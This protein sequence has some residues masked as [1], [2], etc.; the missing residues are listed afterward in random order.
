[1]C[2]CRILTSDIESSVG[3]TDGA[4]GRVEAEMGG[5]NDQGAQGGLSRHRL[6]HVPDSP[7]PRA[8][9][10]TTP[11]RWSDTVGVLLRPR[12]TAGGLD[13]S[14]AKIVAW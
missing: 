11:V 6:Q 7:L 2:I 4:Q 14:S 10:W 13:F 3:W 9:P 12:K 1:M 5:S 8:R